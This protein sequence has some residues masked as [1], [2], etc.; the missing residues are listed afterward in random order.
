MSKVDLEDQSVESSPGGSETMSTVKLVDLLEQNILHESFDIAPEM[1][2]ISRTTKTSMGGLTQK[3]FVAWYMFVI[4]GLLLSGIILVS[5]RQGPEAQSAEQQAKAL[6]AAIPVIIGHSDIAWQIRD[7]F[8]GNVTLVDLREDDPT[9]QS[10]IYD[11]E[12]G[13]V[14]AVL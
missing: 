8:E 2:I 4:V 11:L 13:G 5:I 6:H 7:R 9:L 14:G 10:D 3:L 1:A 12:T